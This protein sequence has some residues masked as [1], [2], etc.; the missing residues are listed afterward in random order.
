M[1]TMEI[2]RAYKF[3]AYPT[4]KQRDL[5]ERHFGCTRFVYNHFLAVR[6]DEYLGNKKRLNYYDTASR[7]KELKQTEDHAWLKEVN[8][9]SLQS[10]L[11]N[12]EVSYS[13]FFRKE[14]AFPRFH[15][16]DGRQSFTVPQSV[17]VMENA[18]RIPKF[19]EGIKC[20]IHREVRGEV[21]YATVS[22]EPSGKYF[23]SVTCR[24]K[25]AE[26]KDKACGAVGIDVGIKELAV[27]SN[28]KRYANEKV[29]E[30]ERDR[31]RHL[32]R[33][34]S[35]KQKGSNRR[36]RA[37]IEVARLH[38]RI[39]NRRIDHLHKVSSE[40]IRENQ[41][42]CVE[43]L[44]VKGMMS[45]HHLAGSVAS[46]SFGE[47]VRQ[48]Q[49]KAEWNGRNFVKIGRFFPSSKTCHECGFIKQDLKLSDRKWVCP[50]CGKEIDRDFNAAL[51][52]L[53]QGMNDLNSGYG[54]QSEDKQ[55]RV[56]SLRSSKAVKREA[57]KSLVSE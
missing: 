28:G 49:Y 43:D 33:I 20:R 48:L 24:I 40:I 34:L 15:S 14:A 37:R 8:A 50:K 27:C 25:D 54:T 51:N 16:K 38:E 31:L 30:G 26:P 41:T 44:N 36:K 47:L 29:Y 39:R 55:K 18:V 4:E 12:L 21:C 52:I 56:E 17:F 22:R 6:R 2:M 3:R 9:Q 35:R 19:T 46:S 23:I 11:R 45:N 7:L 10:S 13:K 42:I 57:T 5:L 53:Q 1:Q 32:Q